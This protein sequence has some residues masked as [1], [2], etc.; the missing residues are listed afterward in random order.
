MSYIKRIEEL[1]GDKKALFVRIDDRHLQYIFGD[2][3][4]HRR[5]RISEIQHLYIFEENEKMYYIDLDLS[6]KE[7]VFLS[8]NRKTGLY[9]GLI[10][11]SCMNALSR[12]KDSIEKMK[13]EIDLL[14]QELT[15]VKDIFSHKTI[16][17]KNIF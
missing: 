9:Y 15:N 2:N 4:I 16:R 7:G 11:E 14:E 12:R 17:L 8:I 1:V 10:D 6:S 13:R 5:I 3:F